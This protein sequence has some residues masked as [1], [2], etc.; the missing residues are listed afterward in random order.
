MKAT[1]KRGRLQSEDLK[2]VIDLVTSKVV[3]YNINVTPTI[4]S[5]QYFKS[6]NPEIEKAFEEIR[7]DLVEKDF[8]PFLQEAEENAIFVSHRPVRKYRSNLLNIAL[9][10]ATIASTIYVGSLFSLPF[11]APGSM[12]PYWS[13][14]YGFA[15]FSA[16]LM[17]ILGL[18]EL[19]HF[20][21][22]RRYHVKASFPFFIPVPFSIGTFGAFISIRDPIPDRKSMTEIGAAGPLVGFATSIPLLFVANYLQGVFQPFTDTQSF[23][24]NFPLIYHLLGIAVPH[25]EP[26]FPMVL[27]VW[28]GI[29]ATAMNLIPV[30]QLDGGHVARGILGRRATILGYIFVAFIIVI[31]YYYPGWIFLVFFAIF[32]GLNHPPPLNDYSKVIPRDILIGV[33]AVAMFV[34]SFTVIPIG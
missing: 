23:L 26:L 1:Q 27:A 9:F 15:F 21:V 30:S 31:S 33:A 32:L 10:F 16:P 34:L 4:I 28:V 11:I 18:H 12:K 5:F 25:N 6:D 13:I 19:G 7:I 17:L 2:Y 24:V 29:F 22:A 14:L 8:I 3:A 20:F